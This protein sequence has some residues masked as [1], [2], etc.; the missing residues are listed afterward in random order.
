MKLTLTLSS[1]VLC[2]ALG[3]HRDQ[4]KPTRTVALLDISLSIYPEEVDREFSE[5]RKLADNI[6][7]GDE[8]IL[9]PIMGNAR[10]DTPGHI[11]RLVAPK[12]RTPFDSDMRAFRR[13]VDAEIAAMEDW[14][15]S[16][17]ALHTDILGSLAVAREQMGTAQRVNAELLIFS[18]FLEDETRYKFAKDQTFTRVSEARALADGLASHGLSIVCV[19]SVHLVRLRSRDSAAISIARLEAVDAFWNDLLRKTCP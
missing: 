14:A 4:P 15:K 2:L 10:N 8:L 3:C 6:H 12:S 1:L 5:M 13:N 9:I 7:R 17:P 16:N 19:A 11:L 18:D